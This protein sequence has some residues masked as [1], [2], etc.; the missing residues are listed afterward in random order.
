MVVWSRWLMLRRVD[1]LALRRARGG[2]EPRGCSVSLD[3]ESVGLGWVARS[4]LHVHCVPGCV[5]RDRK[6]R[7]ISCNSLAVSRYSP[8]PILPGSDLFNLQQK[9]RLLIVRVT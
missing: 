4:S 7:F 1:W 9:L 2:R 6:A 5:L 8:R 3:L